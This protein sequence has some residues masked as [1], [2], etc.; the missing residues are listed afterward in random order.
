MPISSS[1]TLKDKAEKMEGEY[2]NDII[3]EEAGQFPLVNE[4]RESIVPALKDGEDFVGTIYVFGTGGN[5]QKSSKQF[6]D[7]WHSADTLGLVK[8][9]IAGPDII[10]LM[11]EEKR[12]M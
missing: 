10:S 6:R 11:S 2:F 7:M 4:A 5:M 3:L 1:K 8:F 12:V 9:F